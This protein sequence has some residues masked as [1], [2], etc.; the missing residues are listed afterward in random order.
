MSDRKEAY[1][2]LVAAS[3]LFASGYIFA[4]GINPE[5]GTGM[6]VVQAMFSCAFTMTLFGGA[7]RPG[8][9][10]TRRALAA[11]GFNGVGSPVIVYL[12]MEG[13]Q[14]VTPSLA[15]IL[16][17]SNVLMIAALTWAL[18]RKRFTAAQLGALVTGFGGIIWISLGN[19]SLGGGGRGVISLLAAAVLIAALTVAI[20]R[21]IVSIGWAAITRWSFWVAAVFSASVA[22]ITG[23]FGF[24]SPGQTALALGQGAMALGAPVLMFNMGISR[25][26]SA[27]AAAFKLLIPFF[28]LIYGVV[29][30]G[31]IPDPGLA[32]AGLVVV[33]SV[34][35]YQFSAAGAGHGALEFSPPG[36]FP[37]P[38]PPRA[39]GN[40]LLE[41]NSE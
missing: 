28:A 39:D 30:L 10:V 26:G 2:A 5:A 9:R 27:D 3:A 38:A 16:V 41:D 12:V 22:L 17:I 18:G 6:F 15:A 24:H 23:S 35:V 14:V 40:R 19:G 34:A 25:L 36:P 32:L 31:E 33:G 1:I 11:V 37:E 4:R 7:R 8:A 21:P 13:S 29:M 20:E